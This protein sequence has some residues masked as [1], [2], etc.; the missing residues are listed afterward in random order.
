MRNINPTLYGFKF[1]TGNLDYLTYGAKWFRLI[2][3]TREY[4]ILEL[5]NWEDSCGEAEAKQVGSTYCMDLSIVDLDMIDT[6]HL[7]S[8]LECYGVSLDQDG[9]TDEWRA[10]AYHGYG[11][12]APIDSANTSNFHRTFRNLARQSREISRDASTKRKSMQRPVNKIGSTAAEYM[13]GDLNAAL[14]R[15][16]MK[17]DPTA[18][19]LAKIGGF[20]K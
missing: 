15:G 10:E 14:V 7:E 16:I 17:E 12:R 5:I 18:M 11:L 9:M 8:A 19:L 1:L 3:E 13:C 20:Q 4:H 2:P 6:A